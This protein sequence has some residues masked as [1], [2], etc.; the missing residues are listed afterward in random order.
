MKLLWC[1]AW[2]LGVVASASAATADDDEKKPASKPAASS[3]ELNRIERLERELEALKAGLPQKMSLQDKKD[4]PPPAPAPAKSSDV[5]FRA[6]FTDGFHIKSTDGNFDLHVGGRVEEEYRYV[7]DRPTVA[8]AGAR[9]QPNTFLL[10]ELFISV[11]GTIWKDWGFKI[12]GDFSPQGANATNGTGTGAIA[13]IAYLEYKRFKEFTIQF[14]QFKE[15]L[16]M[17]TLCSAM[18][19]DSI[20]RSPMSRFIPSLELGA[21]IYGSFWDSLLTYQ[22]AVVNGR[23]HLAAAGANLQDDNDGKEYAGRITVAPFVQDKESIL[24]G[25]RLGVYGTMAHVGED[26]TI[27][28]AGFPG[29]IA[30]RG[31][32]STYIAGFTAAPGL[33]TVGDRYRVGGEFTY[34]FGP[35]SLRGEYMQRHDEFVVAATGQDSLIATTGYYGTVTCLL[36]GE[37]KIPDGRV[38]PLH[39][40]N[41]SEGSWGAFE[42]V[43]KYGVASL[44]RDKLVDMGVDMTQNSNRVGEW[45]FGFN[46]WPVQNVRVALNYIAEDYHQGVLWAAGDHR[47]HLHGLLAHF[48]LDF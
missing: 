46:W 39:P 24:K 33:R 18:F 32:N 45:I 43:A 5:E 21:Q 8:G 3:D 37:N 17:E 48:Q 26:G 2:L 19:M 7:F 9:S 4:A 42:L 27:N 14:G 15:P 11:D 28:P 29:G 44:E 10:R 16:S 1:A 41:L 20:Q 35:F 47:S 40:F 6:S 34:A 13:E 22:I 25:L 36:T 12:N 31:L 23:S 38:V 30:T